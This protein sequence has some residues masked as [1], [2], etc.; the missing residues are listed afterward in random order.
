MFLTY[1]DAA[2]LCCKCR[3][4]RGV[5]CCSSTMVGVGMSMEGIEQN[6]IVYDLMSE[7]AFQHKTIDV[8]T[9]VNLYSKRRYGKFVQTMQDAWNILYHTIYNC[10]DGAYDKN[11]DVIVSFPDVDPSFISIAQIFSPKHQKHSIALSRRD[12]FERF[13]RYF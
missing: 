1:G 9:W 2:Q 7:M 11:R 5:R 3:N 4:V 13:N 12:F 8:E 6:P 10:T